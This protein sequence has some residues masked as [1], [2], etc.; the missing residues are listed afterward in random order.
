MIAQDILAENS[1]ILATGNRKA[2]KYMFKAIQNGDF[3]DTSFD[4]TQPASMSIPTPSKHTL[5]SINLPQN[6]ARTRETI[7]L[8]S[9]AS[10]GRRIARRRQRTR[11][12]A[13]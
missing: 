5:T 6:V 8:P 1:H 11:R 10:S 9:S 7:S 13:L 4:T 12:S 2:R 3:A